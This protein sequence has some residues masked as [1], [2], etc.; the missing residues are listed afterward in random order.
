MIIVEA[1]IK[2]I[3]TMKKREKTINA[4]QLFPGRDRGKKALIC[5]A[6]MQRCLQVPEKSSHAHPITLI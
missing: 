3:K 5:A 1:K 4:W 2:R 6:D